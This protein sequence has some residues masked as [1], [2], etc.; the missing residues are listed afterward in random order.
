M[1]HLNIFI[2][3]IQL[4]RL[5]EGLLYICIYIGKF[6]CGIFRLLSHRI[7]Y[8]EINAIKRAFIVSYC[9]RGAIPLDWWSSSP[10]RTSRTSLFFLHRPINYARERRTPSVVAQPPL[11]RRL[12]NV[13]FFDVERGLV[14]WWLRGV[15]IFDVSSCPELRP[16]DGTHIFLRHYRLLSKT[17][18]SK[19]V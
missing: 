5:W 9:G 7:Y 8:M 2:R 16:R 12:I 4:C 11:A 18:W 1:G 17:R 10:F 14:G 15:I 6:E 3:M 19:I 13:L